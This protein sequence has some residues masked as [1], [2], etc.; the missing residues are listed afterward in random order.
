MT[1]VPAGPIA[2]AEAAISLAVSSYRLA[3]FRVG[4]RGDFE[5]RGEQLA[6]DRSVARDHRSEGAVVQ[7]RAAAAVVA[8]EPERA[9]AALLVAAGG[10]LAERGSAESLEAAVSVCGRL[11]DCQQS[12]S[13]QRAIGSLNASGR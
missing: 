11:G 8:A 3:R 13:L 7:H 1:L 2:G 6:L 10:G 4:V 5:R 12:C 9:G